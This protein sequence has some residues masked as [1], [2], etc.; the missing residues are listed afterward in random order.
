[1]QA[2]VRSWDTSTSADEDR[3]AGWWVRGGEGIGGTRGKETDEGEETR[4]DWYGGGGAN[5]H[6]EAEGWV[7]KYGKARREQKKRQKIRQMKDS[8]EQLTKHT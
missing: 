7:D 5:E 3:K 1:M 6:G 2:N 4:K 8:W